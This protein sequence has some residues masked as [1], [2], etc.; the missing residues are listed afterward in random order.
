[1]RDL[2]K[3]GWKY[4]TCHVDDN[5]KLCPMGEAKTIEY[6]REIAKKHK[7]I[8]CRIVKFTDYRLWEIEP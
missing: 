6:A 1:M 3:E 8:L 4:I 7:H 5:G 2:Y